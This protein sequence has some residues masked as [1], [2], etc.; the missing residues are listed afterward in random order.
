MAVPFYTLHKM[1]MIFKEDSLNNLNIKV[2]S[3]LVGHLPDDITTCTT[4]PNLPMFRAL[5]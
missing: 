4:N 1:M 3:V 5:R 2:E